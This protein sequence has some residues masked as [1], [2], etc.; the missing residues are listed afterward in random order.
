MQL[1]DF[2]DTH[3]R[4][5]PLEGGLLSYVIN[6]V[7]IRNVR[8]FTDW[9]GGGHAVL[10]EVFQSRNHVEFSLLHVV[11]WVDGL[12]AVHCAL[13]KAPNLSS[14]SQLIGATGSRVADFW[15]RVGRLPDEL[16]RQRHIDAELERRMITGP[17]DADEAEDL[18]CAPFSIEPE[19]RP[20]GDLLEYLRDLANRRFAH[21]DPV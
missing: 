4:G 8:G 16:A 6:P 14:L 21:L 18:V 7:I 11:Q 10:E 20:A 15:A 17:R 12:F 3:T 19:E 2:L 1:D 9:A 5:Y 13:R